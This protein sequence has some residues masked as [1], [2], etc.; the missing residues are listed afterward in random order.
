MIFTIAD[1]IV[2]KLSQKEEFSAMLKKYKL[3][4]NDFKEIQLGLTT[5]MHCVVTCLETVDCNYLKHGNVSTN[6][7][8]YSAI[9]NCIIWTPKT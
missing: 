9:E 6:D 2:M 7:I 8:D 3:F 1:E 5:F 4:T